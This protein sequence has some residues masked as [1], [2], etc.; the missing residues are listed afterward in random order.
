MKFYLLVFRIGSRSRIRRRLD[1]IHI[2]RK[3]FFLIR[4][5]GLLFT[6]LYL[7]QCKVAL[8][9]YY[10]GNAIKSEAQPVMVSLT[11]SGCPR[12]IPSLHRHHIRLGQERGDRLVKLY[13]SWFTLSVLI[14]LCKKFSSK[15][16]QSITEVHRDELNFQ[17][18]HGMIKEY[19]PK[20]KTMYLD[21]ITKIPINLGM[22]WVPTQPGRPF[23][24]ELI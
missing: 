11:R 18:V 19:I 4:S 14:E 20:F 10:S 24:I 12:I 22:S 16:L 17:D 5:S 3:I 2:A 8:M 9:R 1:S 13:L 23:L 6:A 7:K 15:T 21:Q